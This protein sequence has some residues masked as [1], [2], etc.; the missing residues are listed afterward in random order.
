LVPKK[1]NAIV[2]HWSRLEGSRALIVGGLVLGGAVIWGA[3]QTGIASALVY[4]LLRKPRRRESAVKK[5][6]GAVTETS[7]RLIA[8]AAI[9]AASPPA[10]AIR[11]AEVLAI[12]YFAYRAIEGRRRAQGQLAAR[13]SPLALPPGDSSPGQLAGG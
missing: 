11:V 6:T 1:R 13:P 5:A 10:L 9:P 8:R 4:R 12:S 7:L 2:H 3:V